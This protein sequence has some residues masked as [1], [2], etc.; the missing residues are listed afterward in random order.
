MALVTH[1][2]LTTLLASSAGAFTFSDLVQRIRQQNQQISSEAVINARL[3]Y[4]NS[5]SSVFRPSLDLTADRTEVFAGGSDQS[6]YSATTATASLTQTILNLSKS[7]QI[8]ANKLQVGSAE[9]EIEEA[10]FLQSIEAADAFFDIIESRK[11]NEIYETRKTRLDRLI[12][13]TS[14]LVSVKAK[15]Q[16]D[17]YKLQADRLEMLNLMRENN[18]TAQTLFEK[19]KAQYGLKDIKIEMLKEESVAVAEDLSSLRLRKVPLIRNLELKLAKAE[20]D[21]KT[22]GREYFPNLSLSGGYEQKN[23]EEAGL[24]ARYSGPFVRVSLNLPL[25]DQGLRMNKQSG[26]SAER[27]H[28]GLKLDQAKRVLNS[29]LESLKK[30]LSILNQ[31]LKAAR[32]LIEL[33]RKSLQSTEQVYRVGKVEFETYHSVELRFLDAEVAAEG[34]QKKISK[35]QARVSLLSLN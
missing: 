18:L 19:L 7:S 1:I 12:D 16:V 3:N 13:T 10:S 33:N 8:D 15:S 14:K 31:N 11:K 34:Y 9:Q 5:N 28:L 24:I 2:I 23:I 30:T 20:Q 4:E 22:L 25:Y 35:T 17:L 21:Q 27:V 32:E 29:E 26:N 6:R